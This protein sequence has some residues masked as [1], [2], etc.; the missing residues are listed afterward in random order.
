MS[1]KNISL[2]YFLL[3]EKKY[4]IEGAKK[5]LRENREGTIKTHEVIT[6][7]KKVRSQLVEIREELK[8]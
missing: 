2:I 8:K 1:V 3:K 7:L 4:T 6:N 5:R